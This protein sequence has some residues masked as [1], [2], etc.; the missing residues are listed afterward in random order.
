MQLT[1]L[2]SLDKWLG[3]RVGVGERQARESRRRLQAVGLLHVEPVSKGASTRLLFLPQHE[4][5]E[6]GVLR[7]MARGHERLQPVGQPMVRVPRKR[8]TTRVRRVG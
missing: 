8:E 5:I 3:A 1:K 7:A 6:A 2:A 4:T